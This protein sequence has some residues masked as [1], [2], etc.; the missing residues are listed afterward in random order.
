LGKRFIEGRTDPA[1]L[2]WAAEKLEL[3]AFSPDARTVAHMV[4][5]HDATVEPLCV[6]V[7]DR[8]TDYTCEVSIASDE[9]GR[10]AG[11]DFI[12]TIYSYVFEHAKKL[13][14]NMAVSVQNTN[15]INMHEKLG[16]KVDGRL[17][18]GFGEGH[19]GILYG[20]TKQDY[21]ASKWHK[22]PDQREKGY[23]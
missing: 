6:V 3:A 19:D 16:H 1:L 10:W 20:F 8:W 12:R 21:L 22:K 13:R 5:N 14:M 23:E 15:A 11:K 4:L 18:D 9:T 17:R 7:F 2:Q